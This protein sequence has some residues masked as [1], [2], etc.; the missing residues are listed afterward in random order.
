[1]P[2]RSTAAP[3]IGIYRHVILPNIG[4]ALAAASIFLFLH[5]WK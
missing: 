5:S 1:M 4:P 3:P 2:P